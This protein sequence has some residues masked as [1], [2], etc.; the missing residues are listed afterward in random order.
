MAVEQLS[1]SS[2][3]RFNENKDYLTKMFN[4]KKFS[5]IY[6]E[7]PEK[8]EKSLMGESIAE[9]YYLYN[10]GGR[11]FREPLGFIKDANGDWKMD[12]L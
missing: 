3:G 10:E 1:K 11:T 12:S 6:K 4:E 9:F 5:Q 7:Y 8:I 2:R